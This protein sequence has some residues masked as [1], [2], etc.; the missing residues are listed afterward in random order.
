LFPRFLI[1][2]ARGKKIRAS[3]AAS[4]LVIGDAAVINSSNNTAVGNQRIVLALFFRRCGGF[5]FLD[6]V[7]IHSVTVLAVVMAGLALIIPTV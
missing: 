7:Q 3:L 2:L 6:D 4:L 1:N 5:F